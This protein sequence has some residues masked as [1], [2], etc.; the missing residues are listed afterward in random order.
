MSWDAD[1]RGYSQISINGDG[2]KFI[3]ISFGNNPRRKPI[4][5]RKGGGSIYGHLQFRKME[6][7]AVS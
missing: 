1:Y 4:Q 3:N 2:H 6:P 5:Y 7:P